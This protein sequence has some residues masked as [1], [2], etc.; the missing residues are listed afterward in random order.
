MTVLKRLHYANRAANLG[1]V[2]TLVGPPA[3]TSHVELTPEGRARLGIPETLIRCSA[4]IENLDDLIAD[5]DQAL[6]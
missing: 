2:D 1:S 4:G 3:V 5:F 6:G